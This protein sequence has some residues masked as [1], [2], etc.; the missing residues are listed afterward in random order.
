MKRTFNLS[1]Q[2]PKLSLFTYTTLDT[3][4]V[5]TPRQGQDKKA[6]SSEEKLQGRRHALEAKLQ[7]KHS[8]TPVPMRQKVLQ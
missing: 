7:M 8:C 1:S 2:Y 3:Y 4:I 5:H 6:I